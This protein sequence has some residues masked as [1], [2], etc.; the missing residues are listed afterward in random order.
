[1]SDI[2]KIKC[3]LHIKTTNAIFFTAYT[4]TVVPCFN[5]YV[6]TGHSVLLFHHKYF[7]SCVKC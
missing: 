1:M 3:I 5:L 2:H 7:I 6:D 4:K